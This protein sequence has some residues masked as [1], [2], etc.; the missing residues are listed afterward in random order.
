MESEF[1]KQEFIKEFT[2]DIIL[3]MKDGAIKQYKGYIYMDGE[4]RKGSRTVEE[5][6]VRDYIYE[7]LKSATFSLWK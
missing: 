4:F 6:G 1:L 7:F 5:Q 2:D 3:Q